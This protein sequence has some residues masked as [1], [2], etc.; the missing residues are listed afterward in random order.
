MDYNHIGYI[1][2]YEGERDSGT[3]VARL[4]GGWLYVVQ[5]MMQSRPD[6]TICIEPVTEIPEWA[7]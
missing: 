1:V 3:Y 7:Q 5:A 4:A 2:H 6:A